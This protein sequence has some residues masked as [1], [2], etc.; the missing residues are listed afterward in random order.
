MNGKSAEPHA[1]NITARVTRRFRA[2]PRRV[3]DAWLDPEQVALWLGAAARHEALG[4]LVRVELEPCVGGAFRFVYRRNDSEL[5]QSGRYLEI[6]P[7]KRLVFTWDMALPDIERIVIAITP[8][9]D[10]CELVLEHV[11]DPSWSGDVSPVSAAWAS[12]VE[13]LAKRLD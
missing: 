5:V 12:V 3:F 11:M 6:A 10:G 4:E 7:P 1:S 13:A 2:T 8:T 9:A